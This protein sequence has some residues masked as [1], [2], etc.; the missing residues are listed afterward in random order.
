MS[1]AFCGAVLYGPYCSQ[2]G[3][4]TGAPPPSLFPFASAFKAL[5][6]A[7][8]RRI[9]GLA[10]AGGILFILPVLGA[11]VALAYLGWSLLKPIGEARA[12]GETS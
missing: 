8:F 9:L 3:R 5:D 4:P 11:V 10:I 1:C 7:M 2:C 12:T 6:P